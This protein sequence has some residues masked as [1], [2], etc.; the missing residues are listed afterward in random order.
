MGFRIF[1]I[2]SLLLT[3]G[4]TAHAACEYEIPGDF[5]GDC[6]VDYKDLVVIA[7]DWLESVDSHEWSV[8]YDSPQSNTNLPTS[9]AI[10]DGNVYVTG[11]GYSNGTDYDYTTVKYSPDNK[12]PLWVA[13]YDGPG[14]G[15]DEPYDI[16]IDGNSNIYV[17][18]QTTREGTSSDYAIVKYHQDS[19]LPV[20]VAGYDGPGNSNDIAYAAAVDSKGNI[21]VTGHSVGIGD[22]IDC[23]TIKYSPDSNLPVWVA[24]YDGPAKGMDAGY[25]I[26]V[27]SNDNIYV[28]GTSA[29]QDTSYDCITIKYSSDSNQ[30]PWV[31]VYDGAGGDID[32]G[33]AIAI[34]DEGNIFTTGIS[35]GLNTF[36][37]YT[38]IKYQ[39]DSNQPLWVA[40]YNGQADGN[41]IAYDA[42]VDGIGNIYV[43][44][45]SDSGPPSGHDYATVKYSTDSNKPVWVAAYSG[46]GYNYDT[47]WEIEIDGDDN[48]YVTGD[49]FA[50]ET[51]TDYVTIKYGSEAN[52]PIWIAH[53]PA[54]VEAGIDTYQ[55]RAMVIDSNNKIYVTVPDAASGTFNDFVILRYSPSL[56]CTANLDGDLDDNCR[57]DFADYAVLAGHWLEDSTPTEPPPEPEPNEPGGSGTPYVST[58]KPYISTRTSYISTRKPH[59]STRTPHLSTI[60]PNTFDPNES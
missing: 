29:G 46:Q 16:V 8:R 59:V 57:I 44:G 51:S 26:A 31:A 37:D 53:Y 13:V 17:V 42:A 56:T 35:T 55:G 34:D 32:I 45:R 58:R 54:V 1:T 18:G 27:D 39:P 40:T 14:S 3:F 11:A 49:S 5:N 50:S 21:Y 15:K 30:P 25:G 33:T 2:V 19:N 20:W 7:I 36:L 47:G 24:R 22:N 9:I 23:A 48:I 6:I 28:V 38:T 4:Y 60:K 12:Q 41:D 10:D 52:E 43:T